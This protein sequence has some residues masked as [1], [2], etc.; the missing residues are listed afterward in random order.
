MTDVEY[1]QMAL[2]MARQAACLG[3]TPVGAVIVWDDGRIVGTGM[4]RREAGKDAL[5]HAEVEAIGQACRTL[6]GWRLHRAT[7]YVTLEPC[8]M[9]AGAIIN[10]RIKR[11][12]FGAR[13]TKAGCFGSV[14]DFCSFPFNHKPEVTADMCGTESAALLTAFFKQLREETRRRKAAR[15]DNI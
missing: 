10:A 3:E 5:A 12:V 9:C 13:D 2:E 6:G 11:V 8:P 15:K 7:L 1:M 14:C 4:N